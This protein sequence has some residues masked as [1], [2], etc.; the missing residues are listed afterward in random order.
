MSDHNTR[1]LIRNFAIEIVI[2]A[3]LIVAYFLLVLQ[4][5]GEWLLELYQSELR[6]YA[7]LALGLIVVQAVVLEVITSI[8]INR[9]GL[10]RLE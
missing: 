9:L 8:L 10:E 7:F 3:A 4:F 2:Y 5:L 1:R 6:L